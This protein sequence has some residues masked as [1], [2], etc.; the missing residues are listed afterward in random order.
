[1]LEILLGAIVVPAA[2]AD[3]TITHHG[4]EATAAATRRKLWA[5]HIALSAAVVIGSVFAAV[6]ASSVA[7]SAGLLIAAT[8]S[9][10]HCLAGVGNFRVAHR[11]IRAK[12]V[13]S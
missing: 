3:L 1:M 4:A 2:I 8:M 5:T 7:A 10:V 12:G 9:S 11:E 6:I 13:R